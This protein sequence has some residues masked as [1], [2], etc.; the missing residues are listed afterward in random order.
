VNGGQGVRR[1]WPPARSASPTASSTSSTN[2]A[3]PRRQRPR[4]SRGVRPLLKPKPRAWSPKPVAHTSWKTPGPRGRDDARRPAGGAAALEGR[5]DR[6]ERC[7]RRRRSPTRS[8][9][10]LAAR[11]GAAACGSEGAEIL[12]PPE[13][14]ATTR[15]ADPARTGRGARPPRDPETTGRTPGLLDPKSDAYGCRRQ[16]DSVER[17]ELAA[18][19]RRRRLDRATRRSARSRSRP[20]ADTQLYTRPAAGR[21]P[22]LDS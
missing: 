5:A 3:H 9:G 8:C 20:P 17:A 6:V 14:G 15:S 16:H 21:L 19:T 7:R 13:R 22:V 1:A 12:G 10:A 18:A 4:G 2:R 11:P